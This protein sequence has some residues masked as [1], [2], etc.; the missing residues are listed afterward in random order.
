LPR[1]S[2]D[3]PPRLLERP[4]LGAPRRLDEGG[5]EI[6]RRQAGGGQRGGFRN[7]ETMSEM[8]STFRPA[9]RQEKR[10]GT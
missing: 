7:Y 9:F 8:G 1:H 2:F 6:E 4:R 3:D 10:A 5:R